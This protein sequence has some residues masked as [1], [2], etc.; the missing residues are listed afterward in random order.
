[1][2]NQTPAVDGLLPFVAA[3]KTHVGIGETKAYELLKEGRVRVVKLGRKNLVQVSELNRLIADIC[4][5][6]GGRH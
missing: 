3:M 5:H 6:G 4:E 2:R 1:M